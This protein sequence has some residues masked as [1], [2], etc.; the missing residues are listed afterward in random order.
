MRMGCESLH[1]NGITQCVCLQ[2]DDVITI[3][4]PA[5][6]YGFCRCTSQRFA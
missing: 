2:V 3:L 5:V 6:Y 4:S 1:N